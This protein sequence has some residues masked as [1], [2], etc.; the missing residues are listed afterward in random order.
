[1]SRLRLERFDLPALDR[2]RLHVQD[3]VQVQYWNATWIGFQHRPD[4]QQRLRERAER[5]DVLREWIA[6]EIEERKARVRLEPRKVDAQRWEV[7][8]YYRHA[9]GGHV[10]WWSVAASAPVEAAVRVLRHELPGAKHEQGESSRD[11]LGEFWVFDAKKGDATCKATVRVERERK[12]A[13]Q[14]LDC[15][16]LP[17]RSE[18]SGPQLALF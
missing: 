3:L 5:I 11:L 18:P 8:V 7:G 4:I 15:I 14:D 16:A 10:G 17:T 6:I 9:T 1:M 2:L 12:R 13:A